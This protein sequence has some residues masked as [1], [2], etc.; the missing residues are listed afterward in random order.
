MK[1]HYNSLL[2]YMAKMYPEYKSHKGSHKGSRVDNTAVM[3]R[4]KKEEA[5]YKD[6]KKPLIQA[7]AVNPSNCTYIR[8]TQNMESTRNRGMLKGERH[9]Q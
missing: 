8:A 2:I 3:K 6:V 7:N 9:V 1:L 5:N 4:M